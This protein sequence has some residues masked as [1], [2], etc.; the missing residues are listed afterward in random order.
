MASPP[1][2]G[3]NFGVSNNPTLG[4]GLPTAL[5]GPNI[6]KKNILAIGGSPP[7]GVSPGPGSVPTPSPATVPSSIPITGSGNIAGYPPQPQDLSL[8]PRYVLSKSILGSLSNLYE[9]SFSGFP[10]GFSNNMFV[11]SELGLLCHSAILPATSFGTLEVS[12]NFQGINEKFAH[13]RIYP[14]VSFSFY[15]TLDYK[16]I[17]F[18]DD[19]QRFITVDGDA[20]SSSSYFYRMRYPSE[21]KCDSMYIT[22]FEKSYGKKSFT[23][24]LSYQFIQCF[25][26]NI[27]SVPVQYGDSDILKISVEFS[28]DRYIRYK[29]GK[30][31]SNTP[32]PGQVGSPPPSPI[33]PGAVPTP[34]PTTGTQRDDLAIWALSNSKMIN[35]VG[36]SQQKQILSDTQSTF[37]VGSPARDALKQRAISGNYSVPGQNPAGPGSGPGPLINAGKPI[38]G[39]LNF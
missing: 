32:R 23:D 13:T 17:E 10:F 39:P 15:E 19:W 7:A 28:Y 25:P 5:T 16:T 38:T 9:V 2:V 31:A 37:P 12:G 26:T 27:T 18:F 22:K 30:M 6:L 36:T 33:P 20:Q 14:S 8:D 11:Q 34:T 1:P 35:S 21:Y 24:T 3:T 4:A 29:N